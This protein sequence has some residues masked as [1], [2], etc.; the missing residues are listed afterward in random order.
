MYSRNLKN[1]Q[2]YLSEMR[3]NVIERNDGNEDIELY[4]QQ[5]R[6]IN[7]NDC[8]LSDLQE[9]NFTLHHLRK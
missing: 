5:G 3:H 7:L 1:N 9:A 2:R 4:S 6:Q 8:S